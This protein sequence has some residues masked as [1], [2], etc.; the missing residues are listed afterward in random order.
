MY[1][2][3]VKKKQTGLSASIVHLVGIILV[4]LPLHNGELN[5]A[6]FTAL[7]VQHGN[8]VLALV[9]EVLDG[10]FT[11]PSQALDVT[12]SV[13]GALE[14]FVEVVPSADFTDR[15]LHGHGVGADH[16]ARINVEQVI[17]VVALDK[18]GSCHDLPGLVQ[19]YLWK[20]VTDL[21][22]VL[23]LHFLFLVH[24]CLG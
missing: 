13:Q 12:N 9:P 22:V 18:I 15:M 8:L 21:R 24:Q 14:V 19:W 23:L 16:G 2:I 5:C 7:V 1:M 10:E 11:S 17:M 6:I 4:L 3:N 20:N